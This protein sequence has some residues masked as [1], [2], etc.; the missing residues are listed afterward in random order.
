MNKKMKTI[1]IPIFFLSLLLLISPAMAEETTDASWHQFHK[2]ASNSGYSSSLAPDS[3]QILWAS[4]EI[5]AIGSSSPAITEDKIFVNC[6][7]RDSQTNVAFSD[8]K[9]LDTSTGSV[10]W[11]TSIP[12]VEY[13]SWSSPSYHDGN[14]FTSTGFETNCVNATTGEI[15]WTFTST[16]GSKGSVNGGPTIADGKVFCSDWDGHHY[17]CLDEKTGQEIWTFTVEGNSQ[18]T[19]AYD[20]GKVYL[21]SWAYG[22]QYEGRVYCVDV[23]TG[24]QIWC[25]DKIRDNCCGSVTTNN[26]TAYV[27]TYNFYGNAQLLALD[28]T[29]GSVIWQK[30]I[31]R[32][33][34]T[35]ALAYGNVY[36]TGGCDGFSSSLQTYCF[37]A[38]NGELIWE[39]PTTEIIG[40]W[41]CSPAIADG[42]VFVGET[43]PHG[44]MGMSFGFKRIYALDAYTG[45]IIWTS[46]NGGASP[47]ISDGVV[48]SIGSDGRVYAFAGGDATVDLIPESTE[49]P[50]MGYVD[51]PNEITATISNIG[52]TVSGQF[53]A[54]LKV[55]GTVADT[56]AISVLGGGYS[57][58]VTF[59]WI[60]ETAGDYAITVSV[61][62]DD[63]IAESDET[64][65]EAT[66][67]L[68]VGE[69]DPDLVPVSITPASVYENQPYEMRVA[70]D[71]I[72][73]GTAENIAVTIKE[74]NTVI[75]SGTVSSLY[76]AATADY[77]FMWTPASSGISNLTV[78]LDESNGIAEENEDNNNLTGK[79]TVLPET[80]IEELS[81]NDWTQFQRNW[82]KNGST[83]SPAP[84]ADPNVLWKADQGGDVDVTPIIVGDTA[85][86]YSSSGYIR[87]YNKNN[88]ELIWSAQASSGLQTSISA[89][90]DGKLF[91]ATLQGD[92]LAFDATTGNE[93]WNAHLTDLN[94]E[95]PITYYDHRLYIG[96]G[97]AGGVQT[98]HYYCYDD[99]GNRLWAYENNDTAGF[100]WNGASVVGDYLVYPVHEGFLVSLDR[101]SGELVDKINL[102]SSADI[103]FARE[104]PGMFRSSL[105]YSDGYVYTT[106]ERGQEYGLV[107]KVGFDAA[108]GTFLDDG[109]STQN[110]FS[111][112]TPVVYNGRVYVGQGEHGYTGNLTCLNDIDGS[113][114]WSYYI[115]AGIKSSPAVSVQEDGVYIYFTT[116]LENGSLFCLKDNVTEASLSWEYNPPN[117]DAYILQGA[118]I[119]DGKVYFG[120]DGGYLYCITEGDWNPWDDFESDGGESITSYELFECYNCW[121]DGIP[122]PGTGADVTT[123][124]LFQI[125]TA[126]KS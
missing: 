27:T 88:G 17:F 119:S 6:F 29:D 114:I 113:S 106:S 82:L 112:S 4:D 7:F 79:I 72:G 58:T 107:W 25:Q 41:T 111:T 11:N 80:A 84:V 30:T 47:A 108:T 59:T 35:P 38:T 117:D 39:T 55:N 66:V 75:S 94:L 98:K 54:S 50:G 77:S 71:N 31:Q 57:K 73:F 125:F 3:N 8:L 65:N 100:I 61:D 34:S 53:N 52:T 5:D 51:F 126:W 105:A 89:Y 67:M 68:T 96:E 120:T 62:T 104:D 86:I 115:D 16:S 90:G 95:C 24:S 69:G 21:T 60:P 124:D 110:G 81:D 87:A 45:E 43:D 9:A 20:D 49:T 101:R 48:Y 64:N 91:V 32:T 42:K 118:A 44:S 70:I 122:V 97:L 123:Y 93:L 116:A 33:D 36:V 46:P 92:L 28:K 14:I 19:P 102:S 63:S 1:I 103:S 13:G 12:T 18:G 10:L 56:Q 2:D 99:L 76:P 23:A 74:E 83:T 78:I 121:K 15:I 85:Y 22:T 37:N 109:W 40:D 26:D